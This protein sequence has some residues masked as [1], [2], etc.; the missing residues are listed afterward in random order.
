[1]SYLNDWHDYLRVVVFFVSVYGF[2]ALLFRFKN[3]SEGWNTKTR[4]YWFAL[5]MW[6][7]A[8]CVLMIQGVVLDRPFTPGSVFT[9]AAVFVTAKGLHKRGSWGDSE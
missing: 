4:D 1:M 8:G 7:L 5:L 9:M 6:C 2:F 3:R